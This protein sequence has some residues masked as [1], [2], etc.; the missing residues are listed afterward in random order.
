MIFLCSQSFAWAADKE[1][2]AA[3]AN[4]NIGGLAAALAIAQ[5][6]RYT[7]AGGFG[8]FGSPLIT[9]GFTGGGGGQQ[10]RPGDWQCAACRSHNFASRARCFQCM[11]EKP[12]SGMLIISK[13]VA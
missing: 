9:G 2:E 5:A 11:A 4:A 8:A 3:A 10:W 6:Q 13:G 1:K 12:F 7:L